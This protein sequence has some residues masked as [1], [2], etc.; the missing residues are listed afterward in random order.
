MV[1]LLL[2]LLALVEM[3]MLCYGAAVPLVL[4]AT[5]VPH[6]RIAPLGTVETVV[7]LTVH[8]DEPRTVLAAEGR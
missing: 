8:V 2:L 7:P 4:I 5:A 3:R 6:V 1:I